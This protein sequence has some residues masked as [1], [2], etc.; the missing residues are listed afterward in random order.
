[1][2]NV[3]KGKFNYKGGDKML[4]DIISTNNIQSYNVW[5]AHK[6]GLNNSIYLNLLIEINSK[7]IK[8]NRIY[9]DGFFCVDRDYITTR[10]TFN[11]SDQIKMDDILANMGIVTISE[12]KKCVK[13]NLEVITGLSTTTDEAILNSFEKV[14]KSASKESKSKY[15]LRSVKARINPK[16]PYNIQEGLKGWLDALVERFGY[17]NTTIIESAQKVL[18]PIIY[19]DLQKAEEIIRICT[20]NG[21]REMEWGINKYN[22]LPKISANNSVHTNVVMNHNKSAD[23]SDDFF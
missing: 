5:L 19:S 8:K 12:D 2:Y 22:S 3:I 4:I 17:V 10:T 14:K 18:E 1:M 9:D 23:L 16:Y 7:A 15:V 20:V 21:Y 6:I 13:L 11:T